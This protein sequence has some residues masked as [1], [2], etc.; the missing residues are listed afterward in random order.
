MN[1]RPTRCIAALTVLLMTAGAQAALIDRG[2]GFIYDDVLDVTWAQNANINGADI[3]ANQV[4]WAAGYS[5]AHSVYGTF[6]DWRLPTT[7]QPD[8]TCD[9]QF[10][11][12]VS[13][14]INCTGSEMGHLFNV[15]NISDGTPGLFGDIQGD[16]YWSG[17]VYAPDSAC[18]AWVLRFS[19]GFQDAGVKEL[20]YYALA[21]RD[22]DIA[23]QSVVP[24]PAAAW[25]FASAL[26]VLG[27]VKRRS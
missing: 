14:G 9:Q 8:P 2:E 27:W 17:T 20:E 7:V 10:P 15:D 11:G 23:A 12:G 3:W 22:G 19:D 25:L 4:A 16:F 5:Q 24:I 18:C 26:G 13:V 21:V 6:D 1:I